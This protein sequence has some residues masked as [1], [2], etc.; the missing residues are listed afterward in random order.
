MMKSVMPSENCDEKR[1][2]DVECDRRR[3]CESSDHRERQRSLQLASRPQTKGKWKKS[4]QSAKC[5]HE[6]RTQTNARRFYDCFIKLEVSF[7]HAM[8]REIEKN[9]SVL[10]DETHQ[11]NQPHERRNV[12]WSSCDEQQHHRTNE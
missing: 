12:Q 5:R 6:N 1:R 4:K 11:Q 9:D 8:T 7:E 10:H 2:D 3:Q